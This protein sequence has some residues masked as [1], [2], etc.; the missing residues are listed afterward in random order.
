MT[1]VK[2]T[3]AV[4]VMVPVP[5]V[6]VEAAEAISG[7]INADAANEIFAES[8][9]LMLLPVTTRAGILGDLLNATLIHVAVRVGEAQVPAAAAAIARNSAHQF[10]WAKGACRRRP[11][12]RRA[13]G[14]DTVQI[15]LSTGAESA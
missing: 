1:T 6:T 13:Q 10:A 2:F 14:I 4:A 5:V 12:D 3:V 11:R 9:T 8:N 7:S 15:I